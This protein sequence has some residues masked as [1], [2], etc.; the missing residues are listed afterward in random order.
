MVASTV[1]MGGVNTTLTATGVCHD[2]SIVVLNYTGC[3][4]FC[5]SFRQN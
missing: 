2:G 4:G 1:G 3:G 5:I